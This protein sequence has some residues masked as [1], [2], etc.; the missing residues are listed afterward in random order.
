MQSRRSVPYFQVDA[1]AQRPFSGNPAAVVLVRE[2]LDN[3]TMLAMAAENNVSETAFVQPL[4][5]A[6][7]ADEDVFRT[8]S[9]FRLRWWSPTVEVPLCGHGTVATAAVLQHVVGNAAERISFETQRGTLVASKDAQG[10]IGIDMPLYEAV[11][12]PNADGRLD[13]LLAALFAGVTVRTRRVLYNRDTFKIF[14]L[15]DEAS[16]TVASLQSLAPDMEG[17]MRNGDF[18][19]VRGVSVSLR[20]RGDDADA[21]DVYSRYFAPWNGIPEGPVNGSSH[22]VLADIWA[23]ELGKDELSFR[24]ASKRGGDLHVRVD[25]AAQ[26][27]Q[28]SGHAALV[29]KGTMY[30]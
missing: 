19:V 23:K 3:A 12:Y 26:R 13:A 5:D 18:D 9:A 11:A 10:R 17:M 25:R 24:M 6:A 4:D 21:Y 29:H 27:I 2:P 22:T 15:L 14:V 20:A 16:E 8:A 30:M 1:F 7:A 28:L